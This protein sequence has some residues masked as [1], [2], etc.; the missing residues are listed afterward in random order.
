MFKIIQDVVGFIRH[1]IQSRDLLFTL[2]YSDFKEKYA[3]SYL[4]MV[5]AVLRPSIFVLTIWGIFSIGFK[6]DLL[7]TD[8]PFAVYLI[9]GYVPCILILS[10]FL[11]TVLMSC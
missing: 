5:W 6:K 8:I 4:G 1:I 3:G 10:H 11:L 7:G 2:A 9:C